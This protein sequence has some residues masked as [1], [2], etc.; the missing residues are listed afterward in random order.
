MSQSNIPQ[1]N[2]KIQ[3]TA[4]FRGKIILRKSSGKPLNIQSN[5]TH[6]RIGNKLIS[7]KKKPPTPNHIG[8]VVNIHL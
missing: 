6:S 2:A 3:T 7:L 5:K 1:A 8:D 4:A